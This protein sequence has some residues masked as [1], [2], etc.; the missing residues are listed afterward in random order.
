MELKNMDN[1][2]DWKNILRNAIDVGEKV[3]ISDNTMVEI[4]SKIGSFL[5]NNVDPENKEQRFLK[6]MWDVANDSEKETLTNVLMR[7]LKVH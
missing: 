3:G 7:M 1:W 6:E 4:G 5:A 2:N